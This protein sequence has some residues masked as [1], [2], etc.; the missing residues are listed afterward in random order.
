M[1]AAPA[2][3]ATHP[4]DPFVISTAIVGIALPMLAVGGFAIAGLRLEVTMMVAVLL[5]E[6]AWV[7]AVGGLMLG[8]ALRGPMQSNDDQRA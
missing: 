2:V 4:G 5:A 6:S 1:I 8:G 7:I 3:A